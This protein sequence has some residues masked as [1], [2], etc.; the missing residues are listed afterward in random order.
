[1]ALTSRIITNKT[2]IF[3][4][5]LLVA[6]LGSVW[7]VVEL[8]PNRT[9]GPLA[10]VDANELAESRTPCH[11]TVPSQDA[12]TMP[13]PTFC[14]DT[15][16]E[17][18][19]YF[20]PLANGE[21]VESHTATVARR[22]GDYVEHGC[23]EAIHQGDWHVTA[24]ILGVGLIH[25]VLRP[26]ADI[27]DASVVW[28]A[29]AETLVQTAATTFEIREPWAMCD[30]ALRLDQTQALSSLRSTCLRAL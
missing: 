6:L 17:I 9:I 18:F 7:A 2:P 20:E 5:V 26:Q 29:R 4:V 11:F 22:I 19:A 10:P 24:Q 30:A 15:A 14:S 1:M 12:A 23:A 21:Q 28:D 16:D 13:D 3:A 25:D 8:A 27:Y